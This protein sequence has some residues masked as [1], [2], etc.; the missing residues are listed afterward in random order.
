MVFKIFS[1]LDQVWLS[2]LQ[3]RL[4]SLY[5]ESWFKLKDLGGLKYFLGLE[6]AQ[7]K[8]GIALSQRHYT[9]Q[10]LEDSG[11]LACKPTVVPMDPKL[12]LT[13]TEGELLSDITHYRRLVGKLLYLTLSRPDIT[14]A[15]HKLTQFLAQPHLPHLKAMH[16]LLRYLKNSPGQG[17]LFSSHSSLQLKAFSDSDWGSCPNSRRSVTS[18]C[19]F[20]GDSLV[21][22]KAKKQTTVSRSS[23]E[24]EYRALSSTASELIWLQQLLQDFQVTVASPALLYYDNQAAIHIASNP[25]FHERTKHIEIDCHFVRERVASG[26]LK[27][28]PIRFQYQLADLFTK[29][30]PSTQFFSLL[31]KMAVKDIY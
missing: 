28:L 27:L 23:T 12:R 22:W 24:A 18:F 1:S 4:F 13:A 3:V 11:Y 15:V 5:K 29:P 6:I 16:H 20:I 14:F 30:L 9:L 26:V 17:L 8:Q 10:L 19:I 21:S 31:S 25:T 2:S 7:S